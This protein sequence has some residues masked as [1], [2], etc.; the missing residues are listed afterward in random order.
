M[1]LHA[2]PVFNEEGSRTHFE[3]WQGDEKLF[4]QEFKTIDEIYKLIGKCDMYIHK[5]GRGSDGNVLTGLKGEMLKFMTA[6]HDEA[7][8]PCDNIKG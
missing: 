1:K 7:C 3:V 2:Y 8:K 5:E 6:V 4:N